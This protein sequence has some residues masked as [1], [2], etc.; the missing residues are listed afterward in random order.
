MKSSLKS[1]IIIQIGYELLTFI[2]PVITTPYIARVLGADNLGIYAYSYSVVYY[3]QLLALLGIKYYGTRTIAAVRGNEKKL[4]EN[5]T[6]IFLLHCLLSLGSL[7][8]YVFYCFTTVKYNFLISIIQSMNIFSALL[9]INWLFFGLEKFKITVTRNAIIKVITV[10]FIFAF[11]RTRDDLWKYT[12]IM[13]TGLVISQA[14]LWMFAF[15][16]VK[17]VKT[18]WGGILS[19]F[20]PMI[21]LFIPIVSVS[22]L[23]YMDKIMLGI[24]STSQQVGFYDNVHK[25]IEM[26]SALIV[27]VGTVMLP[28]ISNLV[29]MGNI[30]KSIKY[31]LLSYKYLMCLAF[32]MAF[33]MFAI[34]DVFSVVFWG[35]EFRPCGNIIKVLSLSIPFTAYANITRTQFLI[36]NHRDNIYVY[37]T[38]IGMM[39][40]LALN[41]YLL[42]EGFEAIG[43]A[44]ATLVSEFVIMACQM[45]GVRRDFNQ[46]EVI[47]S[48]V[49]FIIPSLVMLLILHITFDDCYSILHLILK[50]IL[51]IFIYATLSMIYFWLIK[52]KIIMDKIYILLNGGKR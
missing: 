2:L 9:D 25:V 32:G 27:A 10:V 40:N 13:S 12:L 4:N 18:N 39:V 14:A 30:N 23:K 20:K 52:D 49:Y 8:I 42:I 7:V 19:N 35:D 34:S 38:V 47:K 29:G 36:P 26:P 48:F 45:Y 50:I 6:N 21:V 15:K 33:G 24:F 43:V 37:S 3:F 5:F 28:K 1:N 44:F 51:G 22:V 31:T 16:Y 11:V 17:I 46:K 41:Y